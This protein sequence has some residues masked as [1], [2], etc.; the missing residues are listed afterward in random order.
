[1]SE[2]ILKIEK[3]CPEDVGIPSERLM[4]MMDHLDAKGVPMHSLLIMRHGKLACEC[5][6]APF[7]RSDTHRMFSVSKTLTA[8]GIGLLEAERKIKL[9]D[10]I[11]DYFPEYV[12]KNTHPW[13]K[14]TTI[15]DM[16]TMRTCHAS[17]TYKINMK[18]D[19]VKS[20]FTV[21]PTHPSG[22]YFH[23]D[24][25]SA[26]TLCALVEK[27]SSMKLIDYIR[28]KMPEMGLSDKAYMLAD[29]FGVSIGGSG[30]IATSEDMLRF[31]YML[32]N[33]GKVCGKRLIPESF[34]N[35]ALSFQTPTL[36]TG[37]VPSEQCG[38][39]YMTWIGE[40][41]NPVCYGMGGQLI[42]LLPEQDMIV[43]TT[44]DTQEISGGNQLIY[45][46]LYN[47]VLPYITD[48]AIPYGEAKAAQFTEYTA[49]LSLQPLTKDNSAFS[50]V[51]ASAKPSYRSKLIPEISGKTYN[52]SD[53]PQG[54]KNISLTFEE[55][56]KSALLSFTLGEEKHSFE[57][58]LG[59][60]CEGTFPI[61]SQRYAASGI[62]LTPDIFYVYVHI[63][64]EYVG[65]I[66]FVLSFKDGSLSVFVKKHEESLFNEFNGHFYGTAE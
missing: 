10:H 64:G 25:S 50:S 19:W 22:R 29:P 33:K 8:I 58:G 27:I 26:H 60:L 41:G 16:L 53:N 31:G 39:G 5:Y 35:K 62:W 45:D 40:K 51:P 14:E 48:D 17:T 12:D 38:Y 11:C 47:L 54:F 32:M 23:Y 7:K 46:A 34:M 3:C 9:E 2:K 13:I 66:K 65:S 37:P 63:I 43:V 59:R 28:F 15:L 20:F 4:N 44:A 56:K 49:G 42:I 57:L 52:L 1:M 36:V 18:D 24:T 21:A 55:N 61:Y 6:Y 30:L